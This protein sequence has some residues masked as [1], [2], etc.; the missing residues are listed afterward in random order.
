MT[1]TKIDQSKGW[2]DAV[3]QKLEVISME[4]KSEST[5]LFAFYRLLEHLDWTYEMSDDHSVWRRG[6]ATMG[7]AVSI[8]RTSPEHQKLFDNFKAHMWSDWKRKPNGDP[9]YDAGRTIPKPPKPQE[10]AFRT[11]ESDATK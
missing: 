11:G 6:S 3:N 9:D 2:L 8:A 7:N 5:S 10:K 4:L 1:I